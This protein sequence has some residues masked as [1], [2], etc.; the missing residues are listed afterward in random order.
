MS[1]AVYGLQGHKPSW[2]SLLIILRH[3][4]YKFPFVKL[5]QALPNQIKNIFFFVSDIV[6]TYIR[7]IFFFVTYYWAQ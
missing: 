3:N 2:L 5:F 1:S 6:A 7:N 4:I